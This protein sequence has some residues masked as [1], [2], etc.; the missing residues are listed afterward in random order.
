[1]DKKG[2]NF[3]KIKLSR[4]VLITFCLIKVKSVENFFK[5]R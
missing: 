1:M 3:Y 4:G 2:T 5:I